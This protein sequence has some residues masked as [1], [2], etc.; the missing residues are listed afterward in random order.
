MKIPL[1]SITHEGFP[2]ER[3]QCALR[4][5]KEFLGARRPHSGTICALM[6]LCYNIF[7]DTGVDSFLNDQGGK[8]NDRVRWKY[9]KI[10]AEE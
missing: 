3:G 6:G 4:G 5:T 10:N 1:L 7:M 8:N 2:Q 9:R